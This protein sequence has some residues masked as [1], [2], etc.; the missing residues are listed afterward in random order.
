MHGIILYFFILAPSVALSARVTRIKLSGSSDRIQLTTTTLKWF[1][2]VAQ[3]TYTAAP[4]QMN[5]ITVQGEAVSAQ[6]PPFLQ[7][8]VM[9]VQHQA[10]EYDDIT[11]IMD[12][13]GG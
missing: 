3:V 11:I 6:V 9:E 10:Y 7:Q 12:L 5:N 4:Q 1:L 8:Q 2:P 13:K